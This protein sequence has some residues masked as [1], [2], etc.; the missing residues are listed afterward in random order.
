MR[1]SKNDFIISDGI[2]IWHGDKYTCPKCNAEVV[3]GFGDHMELQA[4]EGYFNQM[5]KEGNA[6]NIDNL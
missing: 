1:C 4:N 2:C 6:I 5:K 3:V